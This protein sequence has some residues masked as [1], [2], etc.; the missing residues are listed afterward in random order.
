[1]ARIDGNYWGE[2]LTGTDYNDQ[3]FGNGGN[4]VLVSSK[5]YD[6]YDGGVGYDT[7]MFRSVSEAYGDTISWFEHGY[8]AIDLGSIDAKEYS[9]SSASTWGNNAFTFKGNLYGAGLGKGELGYQWGNGETFIYGNTDGDGT[10]ELV[11]RVNGYHTF[12]ANEFV[13]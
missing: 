6:S 3:M 7:Y 1:M 2:V 8:D 10:Y 13:L 9:W 4:D 11:I 5:G 12:S